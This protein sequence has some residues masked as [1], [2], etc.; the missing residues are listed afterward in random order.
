M[1]GQPLIQGHL[2]AEV[3]G[4]PCVP[5]AL[6]PEE[7]STSRG[8]RVP[9]ERLCPEDTAPGGRGS[10]AETS[11]DPVRKEVFEKGKVCAMVGVGVSPCVGLGG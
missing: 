1:T 5:G 6:T 7:G 8:R 3:P 9:Q 2:G 10:R 11:R 4:T